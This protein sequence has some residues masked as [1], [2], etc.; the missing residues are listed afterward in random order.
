[1]QDLAVDLRIEEDNQKRD[2]SATLG[3]MESKANI[4][5][6]ESSKFN[7]KSRSK[8]NNGKTIYNGSKDR[9]LKK[10]KE[11]CWVC[12]VPG[13]CASECQHKKGSNGGK[14]NNKKPNQANMIE[15]DELAT[16]VMETCV[17]TNSKGWW[18]DTGA[19]RY[20]CDY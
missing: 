3:S 14:R 2:K 18:I 17:V 4:V 16:V 20:I 19:T 6:G 5:E 7:S 9:D 13:D 10:I 12:G 15:F 8:G 1:M 11:N